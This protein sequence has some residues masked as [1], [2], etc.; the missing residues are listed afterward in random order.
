MDIRT[1]LLVL[2]LLAPIAVLT[3]LGQSDPEF[4]TAKQLPPPPQATRIL[5]IDKSNASRRPSSLEEARAQARKE[6][7]YL[8]KL[9]PSQWAEIERKRMENVA[10]WNALPQEEKAK[11]IDRFAP[12]AKRSKNLPPSL[13]P[14]ATPTKNGKEEDSESPTPSLP[15]ESDDASAK[16]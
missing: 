3:I 5:P 15:S 4:S 1:T 8:E 7:E 2:A 12:N 14:A 9:T 11:L 10:K 13:P 16:D 6:L